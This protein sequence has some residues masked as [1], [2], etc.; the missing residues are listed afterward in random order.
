MRNKRA[1]E[2]KRSVALKMYVGDGVTE[3]DVLKDRKD[4]FAE[5][6]FKAVNRSARKRYNNPS[7]SQVVVPHPTKPDILFRGRYKLARMR[8]KTKGPHGKEIA[9]GALPTI[10][11]LANKK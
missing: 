9:I 3:K 8:A 1:K 11:A 10:A 2:I 5:P 4:V 6:Q 7:H